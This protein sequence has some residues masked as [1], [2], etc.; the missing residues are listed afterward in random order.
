VAEL[1]GGAADAILIDGNR[2]PEKLQGVTTE[3]VIKGDAK[4]LSVAAASIL[5]KVTR[6]RLML[7]LHHQYPVRP[8]HS[9][10]HSRV[11]TVVSWQAVILTVVS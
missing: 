8:S 11:F 1:K 5:A 4:C 9:R 10:L 7:Q 6:D 2:V 3:A